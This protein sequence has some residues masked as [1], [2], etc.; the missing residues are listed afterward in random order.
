MFCISSH[1]WKQDEDQAL[2]SMK[3][4]EPHSVQPPKMVV[5]SLWTFNTRGTTAVL[6]RQGHHFIFASTCPQDEG[7]YQNKDPRLK[8]DESQKFIDIDVNLDISNV[9]KIFDEEHMWLVVGSSLQRRMHKRVKVKFRS[10]AQLW[11]EI[12]EAIIVHVNSYRI[13][14]YLWTIS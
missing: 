10:Q 3:E 2:L 14:G 1:W 5:R 12:S 7:T 11:I 6:S 8:I 9:L 13:L 4:W